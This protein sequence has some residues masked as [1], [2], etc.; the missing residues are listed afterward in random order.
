MN[1]RIKAS[2]KFIVFLGIGVV[3]MYFAFRNMPVG[4]MLDDLKKANFGW[5]VF[6]FVF[7]IVAHLSRAYRWGILIEPIGNRPKLN[8]LFYSVCS[9]YIANLAFPRLGE[10]TRCTVLYEVEDA[11]F[12]ALVGTVIAERVIDLIML[13]LLIMLTVV[14][15]IHLFGHFFADKLKDKLG[16]ITHISP[17][18]LIMAVL[19]CLLG[20]L[21]VYAGRKRIMSIKVASKLIHFLIGIWDGLKSVLKLKRKKGFLFHTFFIWFMYYLSAYVCFFA[22]PETAGLGLSAALFVLVLGGL[23]M[24][25]P[26]QGG[27]GIYQIVVAGGLLLYNIDDEKGKLFASIVLFSQ[28]LLT[29]IL[30]GISFV[31]LNIEKRKQLKV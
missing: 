5:V 25:A 18:I 30:G 12:D 24:T 17:I 9:G 31:M 2:L 6:S 4:Q 8:N 7:T 19:I 13:L 23:S 3:L 21:L 27:I 22:I 16:F 11:P 15:N 20:V 10:V 1:K 28:W 29:I 26:V 14:S